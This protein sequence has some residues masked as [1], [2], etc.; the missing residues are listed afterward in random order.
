MR[1]VYRSDQFIQLQLHRR[2]VPILGVLN[3]EHHEESDD[4]RA[5]VYDQLPGV[6]EPEYGAGNSPNQDD[7]HGS[8]ESSRVSCSMG[9]P[10]S[11]AGEQRVMV[12]RDSLL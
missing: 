5:R 10:L 8:N 4:G 9:S 12:H 11:K 1:P 7:K 6:T 2:T 3:K